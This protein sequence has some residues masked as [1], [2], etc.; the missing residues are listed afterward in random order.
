M[1]SIVQL[2]VVK[3]TDQQQLYIST[4]LLPASPNSTQLYFYHLEQQNSNT[5]FLGIQLEQSLV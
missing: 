4:S 1:S 5:S 3:L 2:D